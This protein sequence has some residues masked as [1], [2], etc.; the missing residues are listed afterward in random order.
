MS[1]NSMKVVDEF[2][3]NWKENATEYYNKNQKQYNKLET[4][5]KT[6]RKKMDRFDPARKLAV[7]APR[8][9]ASDDPINRYPLTTTA[10]DAYSAFREYIYALNQGMRFFLENY[11]RNDIIWKEKLSSKLD[12]EVKNKRIS[13]INRV[14][15]KAGEI[16]DASMLKIGVDGSINGWI[17]GKRQ[18]VEVQTIYAGGY[19]IQC[20]HYRILVK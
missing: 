18:K 14:Q 7:F 2:L 17:T 16:L 9:I 20:L 3:A 1:K 19:N 4:A 13:L 15:N 8:R 5:W 6:E 11:A 12:K 10:Y